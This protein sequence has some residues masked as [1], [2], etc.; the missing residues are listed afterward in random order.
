MGGGASYF[1]ALTMYYSVERI[2]NNEV[3]CACGIYGREEK[4]STRRVFVEIPEGNRPLV[5]RLR[6]TEHNIKTD[7]KDIYL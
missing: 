4:R 7:L 5:M 6:R 3:R 1:V 2:K